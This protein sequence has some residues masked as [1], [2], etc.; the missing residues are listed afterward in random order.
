MTKFSLIIPC[1]NEQQNLKKLIIE[2]KKI[3]KKNIEIILV[4][5][6]STDDS[7]KVLK[8]LIPNHNSNLKF[9]NIKVNKGYGHGILFG[10]KKA[11]G[12]VLGWTHADLQTHPKD[13]LKGLEYFKK[14]KS[15]E[16]FVKGQRRNRGI[17]DNFFSIGMS[18][19]ETILFQKFFHEINAQ[20][21]LFSRTFYSSWK[22]PPNDFSLD[23]YVYYKAKKDNLVIKRFNVYFH[24]RIFG[25]SKWNT[26]FLNRLKFIKRTMSFSLK[27]RFRNDYN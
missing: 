17:F 16:I 21:N 22:R 26:S 9:V 19:F 10:L 11:K 1:F 13:A 15:E 5:N 27:L 12:D 3:V 4:N 18:F 25:E 2:C 20:P 8:K 14:N 7:L 6:G 23:L 24:D